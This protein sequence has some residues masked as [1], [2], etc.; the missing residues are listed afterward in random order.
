MLTALLL[1]LAAH[2][3]PLAIRPRNEILFLGTRAEIDI[4]P[5]DGPVRPIPL[6]AFRYCE[7]RLLAPARL[8]A[9]SPDSMLVEERPAETRASDSILVTTF[10]LRDSL[11]NAPLRML[12]LRNASQVRP[13]EVTGDVRQALSYMFQVVDPKPAVA[14]KTQE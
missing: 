7:L 6:D 5:T 2:S 10:N 1:T 14:A 13:G 3:E 9:I 12:C 11:S 4:E 8:F